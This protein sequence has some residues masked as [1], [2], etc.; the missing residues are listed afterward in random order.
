[1]SFPIASRAVSGETGLL[2]SGTQRARLRLVRSGYRPVPVASV[3]ARVAARR[4]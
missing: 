1:V 4:W 3:A 2:S